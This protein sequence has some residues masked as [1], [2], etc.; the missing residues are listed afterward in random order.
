[1]QT[2]DLLNHNGRIDNDAV[3]DN[4]NL[5]VMQDAGG[6]QMENG[7]LPIDDKGVTRIVSPLKSCDHIRIFRIQIDNLSFAF[8]TPLGSNHHDVCH[9][10][11]SLLSV[12]ENR[13]I[14]S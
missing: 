7:L 12:E 6:N 11:S 4:T 1:L 8:I 2:V 14:S 10:K 5:M 13:Y 3:T 9:E